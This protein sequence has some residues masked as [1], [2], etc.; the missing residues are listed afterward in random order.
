M[1][2]KL[3][4]IAQLT[5]SKNKYQITTRATRIWEVPAS[6]NERPYSLDMVLLDHEGS[7]IHATIPRRLIND[8]KENLR[9]GV[10]YKIQH[11]EVATNTRSYRPV[12]A[13]NNIIK[14]TPFT[15]IVEDNQNQPIAQHKF[16]FQPLHNLEERANKND[17][18]IDVVGLLIVVENKRQA[19]TSRGSTQLRHIYIQ[20]EMKQNVRVTLWGNAA[21]LINESTTQGTREPTAVVITSTKVVYY[22]GE[23]QIQ[24][25]YGTKIYVNLDIQETR[26]LKERYQSCAICTKGLDK[27]G[28]CKQC[29]KTIEY[30]TQRYR[31]MTK[32]TDGVTTA[33]LVLFNKEAEK[34]IGKPIH[35]LIDIYEKE[36]GKAK[37]YEIFQQCVG[38]PYTFKVKVGMSK[39][40][41]ER[42]LKGVKTIIP[43]KAPLNNKNRQQA[44]QEEE[45]S[46]GNNSEN[47]HEGK[48]KRKMTRE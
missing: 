7:Q 4:T 20:G 19:M 8:H 39:Y 15:S 32:M 16:E 36:D 29:N 28:K 43:A 42:E 17:Y 10:I 23:Y 18:L 12:K 25:T 30:P 47:T 21:E 26:Q 9:E 45:T 34:I 33:N 37:V 1:T 24:S 38:K 46:K 40:G 11:F 5:P 31:I 13:T 6:Q 48:G 27:D 2:S 22:E 35:K 3:T 14:C 41:N 44:H